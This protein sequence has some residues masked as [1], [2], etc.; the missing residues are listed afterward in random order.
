MGGNKNGGYIRNMYIVLRKVTG[1]SAAYTKQL[2]SVYSIYT[3][4]LHTTASIT[5]T[6]SSDVRAITDLL[7][8]YGESLKTGKVADAVNLYTTDG[9]IMAPGFQPS[10]GTENL[11]KSYT[12]IFN[13]IRLEIE[14]SIDEITV[15]SDEWAFARSTAAGTKFWVQKGTS[16]THH[17]QELFVLKKETGEWKIARY[18]F[19]SMKPIA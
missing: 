4:S 7:I 3:K 19:S 13:T 15:A 17:N 11:I 14:S 16:E 10:C 18:C 1:L 2:Y 6:M 5:I 9:V 8:A 12:R